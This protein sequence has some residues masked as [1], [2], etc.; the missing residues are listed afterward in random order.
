M[1]KKSDKPKKTYSL[2]LTPENVDTLKPFFAASGISISSFLDTILEK[3]SEALTFTSGIDHK[4][5][6]QD[7]TLR[8]ISALAKSLDVS[9]SREPGKGMIDLSDAMTADELEACGVKK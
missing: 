9:F 4:K 8:E 5:S 1:P 3:M 2:Y 6:A 7:L